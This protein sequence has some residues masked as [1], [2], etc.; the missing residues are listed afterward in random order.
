MSSSPAFGSSP[1]SQFVTDAQTRRRK[2]KLSPTERK[3][4]IE[5]RSAAGWPGG[6][7]HTEDD[8]LMAWGGTQVTM[9]RAFPYGGQ[10]V[11]PKQESRKANPHWSIARVSPAPPGETHLRKAGFSLHYPPLTPEWQE[12]AQPTRLRRFTAPC[13]QFMPRHSLRAGERRLPLCP[14]SRAQRGRCHCMGDQPQEGQPQ[15]SDGESPSR[16]VGCQRPG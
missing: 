7:Q 8:M 5:A 15:A 14:H 12:L 13:M 11:C 6:P 3:P 9:H 4:E 10:N 16:A 1:H 2:P